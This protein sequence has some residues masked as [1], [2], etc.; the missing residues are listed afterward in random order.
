MELCFID[1]GSIK[2]KNLQTLLS[3]EIFYDVST[4]NEFSIEYTF[5]KKDF[6]I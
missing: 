5:H 3:I 2:C 4:D 6:D 1:C